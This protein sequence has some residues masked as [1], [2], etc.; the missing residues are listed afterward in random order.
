MAQI[1]NGQVVQGLGETDDPI[2]LQ[3]CGTGDVQLL[4]GGAALGQ[5]QQGAGGDWTA[6]QTQGGEA[7][8]Q[9]QQL[10]QP[11]LLHLLTP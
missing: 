1:E 4:D 7:R 11:G 5:H 8:T 9:G 3:L 6:A 10:V 2:I